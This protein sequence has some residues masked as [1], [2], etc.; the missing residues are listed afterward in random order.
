MYILNSLLIDGLG[1]LSY[2]FL[3]TVVTLEF[4]Y[5]LQM[6]FVLLQFLA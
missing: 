3:L 2:I 5:D 1:H 6:K 4:D